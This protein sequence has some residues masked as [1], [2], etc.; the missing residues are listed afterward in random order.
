[1]SNIDTEV[2]EFPHEGPISAEI[3]VGGG[4]VTVAADD[5]AVTTV[6]VSPYDSSEA[7][8]TAAAE[9]KVQFNDGRLRVETPD[10]HSGWTR[11]TGRVRVELA[12]PLDSDLRV[13]V[14]SADLRTDGRLGGVDVQSGSGD[15][16]VAETSG[17]LST[18][19][20]S[21]DLRAESVGG[22]LRVRTGSGD[23]SVASATGPVAVTAAS[24]DI[25]IDEATGAVRAETASGDVRIG[26]A[27][28]DQVRVKAASGDV[29]VGVPSGTK[30]W[31]DLS[32]MSGTT[33]TDLEMSSTA[34][35]GGAQLSLQ[36]RTASGDINVHRSGARPA[37]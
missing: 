14:G 8:V 29:M 10:V 36:I 37:D 12:V 16:Y 33:S 19:S 13:H 25:N 5:R 26:Q 1:M 35:A 2:H 20:G 34:P 17:D 11:R 22:A 24:G 9:T 6:S 15:V 28:G 27:H 30:V 4:A 23:V 31:L 7:S 3:R 18:Q 21:G 32:T